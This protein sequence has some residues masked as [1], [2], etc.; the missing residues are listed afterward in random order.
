MFVT[1]A[2]GTASLISAAQAQTAPAGTT[3]SNAETVE[4][5]IVTAEKTTRSSV[6]IGGAETQKILPGLSPLKA[7]DTLPGVVY[8]PRIPGATTSRTNLLS[9]TASPSSNSATP[10]TVSRWAISNMEITTA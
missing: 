3:A 5:V 2:L 4:T 7:I 6:V 9:F 1:T 10:W 8:K